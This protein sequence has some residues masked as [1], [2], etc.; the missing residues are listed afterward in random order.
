MA[1]EV[2]EKTH[3]DRKEDEDKK[4]EKEIKEELD[5]EFIRINPSKERFNINAEL[6]KIHNHIIESTKK[7]AKKSLIDKLSSE[8]LKLELKKQ[9]NKN[10]LSKTYCLHYKKWC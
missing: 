8:L 7:L 3:L 10:M 9:C 4:R 2:D 6:G 1:V 5:W